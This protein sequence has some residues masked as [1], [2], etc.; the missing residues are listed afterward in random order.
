MH[1]EK[2][3][4]LHS[5]QNTITTVKAMQDETDTDGISAC[6]GDE[7]CVQNFAPET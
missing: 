3:H 1:D 7:I 6:G 4:N 5:S 2:L